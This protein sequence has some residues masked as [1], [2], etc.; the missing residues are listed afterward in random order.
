MI[1][2]FTT[3]MRRDLSVDWAKGLGILICV[4]TVLALEASILWPRHG[5]LLMQ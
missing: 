5:R 1:D 2:R 4:T 3:M